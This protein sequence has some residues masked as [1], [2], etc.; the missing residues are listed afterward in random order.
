[1]MRDFRLYMLVGGMPQAV[2]KYI[3][4]NN[5]AA[6]D[7][8]K[9]DI[10]SLYLEDLNKI[11]SS[12]RASIMYKFIPAQLSKNNTRYQ[13][14]A[15]IQGEKQDRI[16]GIVKKMEDSMTT[17]VAYHS[18]DPNIGMALTAD[19]KRYKMYVNDTGLFI[20]LSFMDKDYT[21]N[22]IYTKLLNDK[23]SAN[24]G[25]VFE[26]MIA[27]MLRATGKELYY[28]TIPYHDGKK[29]YEID[30]LLA[31]KFKVSPIEVKSSGY[32]THAS[33][34]EFC[35]KYSDRIQ[36]KYIIYTKDLCK[37]QDVLHLPIYMT[38]FL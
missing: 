20:T 21:D 10:L 13:V 30:F 38:M 35:K 36:N 34:D 14:G 5:L 9:R 22:V 7:L 6:V 1:M 29:F 25:Y 23:L 19:F 2:A 18:N 12:G 33:L 24:L 37:E 26:N 32:K 4:T 3:E 16:E 15:I 17:N 27:Q 28:H 8:V 31:D 11:D